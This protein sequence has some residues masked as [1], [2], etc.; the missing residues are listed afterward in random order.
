MHPD[1]P[2][3]STIL[4]ALAGPAARLPGETRLDATE[5]DWLIANGIGPIVHHLIQA[6]DPAEGRG[7]N[8]RLRGADL[9]ARV[10]TRTLL[11]DLEAMLE[12]LAAAGITVTLLKGVSY[13]TRTY[14]EPHLRTMGDVDLLLPEGSAGL[15]RDL[16]L[17]AGFTQPPTPWTNLHH[18]PP[19]HHPEA[20]IW[21]ELHQAVLPAESPAASE[22]PFVTPILDREQRPGRLG[23]LP[24]RYLSF[25]AELALIAAGWCYDL[26]RR[27]GLAGLQRPPIDAILLLNRAADRFDWDRVLEWS[28]GSFTGAC[29]T[30]LLGFLDRHDAFPGPPRILD[31]IRRSQPFVRGGTA[32][33]VHRIL[34]RHLLRP[35][36]RGRL[37]THANLA[38]LLDGLVAPRPAWKNALAAPLNVAFP[39]HEPRRF[40][41][42]FLLRRVRSLL[43]PR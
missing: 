15:A 28:R 35:R 42:A 14:P 22:A 7:G 2:L 19:L 5:V 21:L 13:A 18:L 43:G 30:V 23:R 20:R 38:H 1:Q 27:F 25:E 32:R 8:A 6:S 26:T 17:Q 3:L 12:P 39:R 10:L 41:P 40:Q 11:A 24:V 4:G 37:W 31:E 33:L 9:T 16:L 29:M 36:P 34:D